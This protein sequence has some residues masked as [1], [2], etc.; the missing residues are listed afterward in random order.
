MQTPSPTPYI[1]EQVPEG[2]AASSSK[3]A[4]WVYQAVTIA[5]ILIVLG[6]VWLF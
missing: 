5:A 3:T 2:E 4:D 6:S 1:S